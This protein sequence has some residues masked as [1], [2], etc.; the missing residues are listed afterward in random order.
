MARSF[1][2]EDCTMR[3]M[4]SAARSAAR[5]TLLNARTWFSCSPKSQPFSKQME[6]SV[7]RRSSLVALAAQPSST[8]GELGDRTALSLAVCPHAKV[9]IQD[10]DARHQHH[11][12][13]YLHGRRVRDNQ[14][15][16]RDGIVNIPWAVRDERTHTECGERL[17]PCGNLVSVI[18]THPRMRA[19]DESHGR[20]DGVE[21]AHDSRERG[22]CR[23]ATAGEEHNRLVITPFA[24]LANA[25]TRGRNIESCV[26]IHCGGTQPRRCSREE[27]LATRAA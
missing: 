26:A 22:A 15:A 20:A 3:S 16:C 4:T 7:L 23:W 27:N 17:I 21:T 14:I 24:L 8:K 6:R 25:Q 11:A 19:Y 9:L 2:Q 13:R 12:G 5:P 18:R 10:R 1:H